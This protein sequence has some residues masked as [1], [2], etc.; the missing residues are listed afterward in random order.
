MNK[1]KFGDKVKIK[2]MN[3]EGTILGWE[4]KVIN[5]IDCGYTYTVKTFIKDTIP[6]IGTARESALES[7]KEDTYIKFKNGSYIKVMP[8]EDKCSCD[9]CCHDV[10]EDSDYN[11]DFENELDDDEIED[12]KY[13]KSCESIGNDKKFNLGNLAQSLTYP[14][15]RDYYY[16]EKTATTVIKWTDDTI[17]KVKA[18]EGD[19]P[20]QH[21]GLA[22][23]VAKKYFG[24]G[25]LFA[26]EAKWWIVDEPKARKE[27]EEFCKNYDAEQARLEAK[28]KANRERRIINAKALARKREYEARKLAAEKYD[29]PME[30]SENE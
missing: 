18:A 16:D 1:F 17:T 26:R 4:H 12:Y 6:V 29:V 30:W 21:T 25:N 22:N 8:V 15:I 27:E 14:Q 13:N 3:Q 19:T 28:R 10:C 5:G 2:T 11:K 7:I 24:N 20:D 9:C 23:A